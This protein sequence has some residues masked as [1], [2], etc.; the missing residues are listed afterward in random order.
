MS[1]IAEYWLECQVAEAEA[2][3]QASYEEAQSRLRMSTL[4]RDTVNALTTPLHTRIV[5]LALLRAQLTFLVVQS[6]ARS[7]R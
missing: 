3:F 1:P 4:C 2:R 7:S 6:S 5:Q